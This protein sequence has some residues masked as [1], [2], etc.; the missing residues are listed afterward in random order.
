MI[1]GRNLVALAG[2]LLL[3]LVDVA[4]NAQGGSSP[5]AILDLVVW[6]N[7]QSV[8]PAAYDEPLRGEISA[9]IQRAAAYRSSLP[10]ADNGE[11]KMVR[12]AQAEYERRLFASTLDSRAA[13]LAA[14]YVDE[15]GPCYEWE[16]MSECPE[17][18]A[19]FADEYINSHVDSP[20][21]GYLP[22]L[23]AH[24]WLCAA[25]FFRF[26]QS[27]ENAAYAKRRYEIRLPQALTAKNLVIRTAA[28]Q[29]AARRTCYAAR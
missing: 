25:E 1:A 5:N 28:Y 24:R 8:D 19:R 18:E 27:P 11:M 15:L 2:L 9:F 21:V 6:G 22:L 4:A 10:P 7:Y 29:L 16:G 20:L 23:A 13:E 26:E 12:H 14:A 17:R 3:V